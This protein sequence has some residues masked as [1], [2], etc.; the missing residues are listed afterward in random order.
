MNRHFRII[1]ISILSVISVLGVQSIH[2][3]DTEEFTKGVQR[4]FDELDMTGLGVAVVKGD[5]II[6]QQS[7][8]YRQ[9]ATDTT[10]AEPL[11]NDD[12]FRIASISKTFIATVIMQ[13]VEEGKLSL[14]DD[15]QKYL[16]FPLRNPLYKDTPITIEQLLTHTSS[17]N[18]SKSWW[19]V[20]VIDPG[21]YDDYHK[22]YSR[23]K[24]GRDYK[25]CN[26]NYTLLG[27]VIENIAHDK[28]F[29]EVDARIMKPLGL[30][31]GFN[32]NDL[33]RSKFVRLYRYKKDLRGYKEDDEAYRP[34][35]GIIDRNYKLGREFGLA[36]PAS[37]MKITTR[38]LARYMMMHMNGGRLDGTRIISEESEE[39]M[40][41]NFVGKHNYGLSF[42]HYY[43]LYPGK[44][45][46]G[47]T[48]GGHGLKSAM[49]FDPE[50]K[51]GFVIISSGS[52][53]DVIDGY[54]DIH[55][56]I[57]KLAYRWMF[58]YTLQY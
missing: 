31:G 38:D 41:R 42:R 22:C 49:I 14:S 53:S 28:F 32:C 9:L 19:N 17:I 11:H 40:R 3:R 54:A 2:G 13:Y 29:N 39:L 25:Y 10:A 16:S 48:G 24:P 44:V 12:M 5:S 51:T 15:T 7:F 23:T 35:N 50:E 52:K 55:K 20:N 34:Y 33:D 4:I 47:Q 1:V 18:D 43:D 46:S 21:Q 6:Y 57:I 36:Y 58:D 26:M 37:G 45:L 30:G 27:A 56:P 8:G